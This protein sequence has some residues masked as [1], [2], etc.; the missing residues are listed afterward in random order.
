MIGEIQYV[1]PCGRGVDAEE[2]MHARQALILQGRGPL[3]GEG[4][5]VC[6]AC[7]R[8]NDERNRD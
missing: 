1:C 2:E 8:M 3:P 5:N 7:A 4:T 6:A